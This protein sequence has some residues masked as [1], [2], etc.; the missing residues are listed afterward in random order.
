LSAL[1]KN[2][3]TGGKNMKKWTRKV[4]AVMAA[5]MMVS[6]SSSAVFANKIIQ[7]IQ[8]EGKGDLVRNHTFDNGVG[9]PWH[10]VETIPAK[11]EFQI[12]DGK[13][14]VTVLNV[15]KDRWDVQFRHRSIAIQSGHTYTIKFTVSCDKAI[16]IYPKV[17]TQGSPYTE[18][19]NYKKNW[20]FIQLQ[21]NV[22]QT[23]TDTFTPNESSTTCEIAFHIGGSDYAGQVPYTVTFDD[24]Y[25]QDP[26]FPGYPMEEP[27]PSNGIRVN[28]EGYYPALSK[29]ATLVSDSTSA[30]PWQLLNSSGTVVAQGQSTPKGLDH[31]SGDNVQTIDFS[32]YTTEGTGYTLKAGSAV[33]MP[34]DISTKIYSK[35][36]YDAIK[37]FY[38]N[39]SG[40]P[41]TMP[42]ADRQDLTRPAGHTNDV[43][44]P[45]P[46]K[47]YK[48]NY[49]LD[50]T[51]GWYDAGDHGKYVVNGGIST[52]TMMNEYERALLKGNA[53]V[54][55][56][57][58]NTM[59][60]PESGNGYPDILDESRFNLEC[61]LKM[62]VPAGNTLAG[63]VHH[64]AH[65]DRW[66]ALAI[67]PDQDTMERHL[68]PP[69]TAATLNL[70]AIAAQGSRLWKKYDT[71]FAT[72]CLTAAET[73]WDA[74]V[75]HPAIY[76]TMQQGPGGGAYGDNYVGDEF[77]W[78][79]CELYLTTGK[80][81]YLDYM[82]SSKHYLEMP[83]TLTGGEDIGLTGAFDWGNVSGLG[84]IDLALVPSNLPTADVATAKSNIKAAADNYISI[85]NSQGYG[86]PIEEKQ[87]KD[88]LFGFPWGSNSFVVNEA[89]VMSY[90]YEF[91]DRQDA[92]YLNGATTAM[93]YIMGRNP[94]VQC[95]VTGYGE[96]PLE[97]PHHR[98]WAFQA[99]PSFPKA[100]AGCLSGGPNSG[101]DDPWVKGSGW[102]AGSRPAE[103]CFM[104]NIESWSTNE[105]T[106]NWNTPLAWMAAY[107]DEQGGANPGP[108]P[109]VKY[110]DI[111][112]D[113]TVNALDYAALKKYLL[114]GTSTGLDLK[115]ADVNGDNTVNALD[116]AVV[117]QYLLGKI[118]KFP[119]E[120]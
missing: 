100:P 45:D 70:A 105:V 35:M 20:D 43:L 68:Q 61:L 63:M 98:F 94:M 89:I 112:K 86:V 38:L 42:Y 109:S 14:K 17:G 27:E 55:P 93:D 53:T 108:G 16:K 19:W 41:I 77:Y 49:T 71:T 29:V 31:A 91:S 3:I 102:S 111:N 90:A 46:T 64:K 13:Y 30:V 33:S 51:G 101:L 21:P 2:L 6:A 54:A 44:A 72:K 39:R 8:Y 85:E 65:D 5:V 7:P 26:Q 24:M 67:R 107:L 52:W 104:D 114:S 113:G 50:I 12:K 76:A 37:Y 59:N 119:A 84:T 62:Q 75:A 88:D 10:V 83:T 82:K 36:K 32:S 69:S 15:G 66:T 115:A 60:I 99:D 110:G 1:N 34:F 116:F 117:K 74:A 118:T 78:A 120:G 4:A 28:Q 18:Y 73:A 58:D 40:I 92:K 79:A 81:K 23:I 22:P 48:A 106:I 9:L 95:Y 103:K 47:D 25:L 11:S 87:L 97:N 80:D 56:F 57:A 96:N